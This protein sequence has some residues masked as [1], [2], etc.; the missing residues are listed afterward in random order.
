VNETSPPTTDA[1]SRDRSPPFPFIDL[2]RSID[3]AREFEAEYRKS[4]GRIANAFQVWGYTAK[5]SSGQQT[6]GALKAFGLLED[7]GSGAER[8]V[9]LTDLAQR[10]L[11]DERP[12]KRDEAIKEAALKPKAIA[13]RWAVW[14]SGRPPDIECRSELTL[15]LGYTDDAADRFI[16][17]YDDTLGFAKIG[18]ADKETDKMLAELEGPTFKVGD[19]VQW[20]SAGVLQF[21]LPRRVTE[22]LGSGE[23]VIVEGSNTGVPTKELTLVPPSTDTK[24]EPPPGALGLSGAAPRIAASAMRQDV[25]NLDEGPVVLQYPVKMS[26]ASYQ[27]FED[28]INL[29]LKKIK[30]GS[31]QGS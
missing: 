15:E 27:D 20:E 7:E 31:D 6:I 21:A 5:S 14:R 10:I 25:F 26:A 4:A 18:T 29:Q 30:R 23:F 9:K 22:I 8:K 11:K 28:W 2:K 1:R 12:G 24:I 3:R 16:Q 13:E 19:L 17:V